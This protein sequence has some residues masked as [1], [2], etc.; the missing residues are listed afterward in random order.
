MATIA[1]A[2]Q[3]H[4]AAV[5]AARPCDTPVFDGDMV[6]ESAGQQGEV[7]TRLRWASGARRHGLSR[8]VDEDCPEAVNWAA[9]IGVPA[10]TGPRLNVGVDLLLGV[11]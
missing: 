10:A 6:D 7:L 2:I 8:A 9:A 4:G 3:E 11:A 1:C 5:R